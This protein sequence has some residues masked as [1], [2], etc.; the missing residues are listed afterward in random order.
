MIVNE[1]LS[2][3]CNLDNKTTDVN[4]SNSLVLINEIL[5]DATAAKMDYNH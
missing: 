1:T 5:P 4:D 2:I 3:R